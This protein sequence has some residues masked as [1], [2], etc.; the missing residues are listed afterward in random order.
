MLIVRIALSVSFCLPLITSSAAGQTW[1]SLNL[2][3]A[4]SFPSGNNSNSSYPY[5]YGMPAANGDPGNFSVDYSC[6]LPTSN[7]PYQ[8]QTLY[9]AATSGD[10]DGY[11]GVPTM[12]DGAY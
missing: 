10:T 6:T 7:V 11:S 9:W 8:N 4:T 3:T 12:L 5:S 2:S 1:S